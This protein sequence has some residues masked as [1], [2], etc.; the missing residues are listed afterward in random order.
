MNEP[1]IYKLTCNPTGKV[2][3]GQAYDV[4][5]RWYR[6]RALDCKGQTRLH[7]SLAK[8]GPENFT[9]EI[10]ASGNLETQELLDEAEIFWIEYFDATGPN[11]L[12][13]RS[14]GSRGR[15]CAET[16]A[17]TSARLMGHTV[18]ASTRQKLSIAHTGKILSDEHRKSMSAASKSGTPEMRAKLSAAGKAYWEKKRSQK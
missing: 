16:K 18:T 8:Y 2:Y 4:E 10:W 9:F 6:Y 1:V 11:G 17:K 3:I 14:G 7:A 15:H 5:K 13:C 12:N